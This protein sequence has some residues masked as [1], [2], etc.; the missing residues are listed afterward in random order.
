MVMVTGSGDCGISCGVQ[1]LCIGSGGAEERGPSPD[2]ELYLE[3]SNSFVE[4]QFAVPST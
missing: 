1:L 4:M 3:P 2:E